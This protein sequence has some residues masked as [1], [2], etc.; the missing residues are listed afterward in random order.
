MAQPFVREPGYYWIKDG[1]SLSIGE[2][3][4]EEWNDCCRWA[5]LG[6]DLMWDDDQIE[7]VGD[8]IEVPQC[9][10]SMT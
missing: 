1:G 4:Y 9:L 2:Y 6:N 8:R 5:V 7:W 10:K 3:R